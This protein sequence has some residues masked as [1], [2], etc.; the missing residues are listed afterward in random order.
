ML[1]YK[2]PQNVEVEDT[3]IGPITMRQLIILAIGGGIAYLFYITLAKSYFF[4]V[5]GPPVIFFSLTSIC[6]AFV[7]I[8]NISFIKWVL[9]MIE[10]MMLP[11]K[12]IWDKRQSTQFIFQQI[13]PSTAAT[14]SSQEK[15]LK[16]D[17]KAESKKQGI[18]QLEDITKAL[19]V[20]SV[21]DEKQKSTVAKAK[22]HELSAV[23]LTDED[24]VRHE[25]RLKNEQEN[26]K[27]AAI[28]GDSIPVPI[29]QIDTLHKPKVPEAHKKL[30]TNTK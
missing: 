30:L 14:K 29:N 10:Y 5:W 25:A 4:E 20:S 17:Q 13:S 3:I 2:I 8:K 28:R 24:K 19:D 11:K 16:M 26:E 1:Q 18:S 15:K 23:A 9:L 27:I 7:R 12:R 22:D 21:L 6:I